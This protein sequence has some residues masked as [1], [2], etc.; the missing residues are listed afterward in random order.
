MSE[1]LKDINNRLAEAQNT[2]MLLKSM[3]T[4]TGSNGSTS[5]DKT[6]ATN[7]SN[8][9]GIGDIIDKLNIMVENVRKE[10]Y[11]KFTEKSTHENQRKRIDEIE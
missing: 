3:G 2:I 10:M 4:V 9:P 6:D 1:E 7:N 11:G 5:E 8:M